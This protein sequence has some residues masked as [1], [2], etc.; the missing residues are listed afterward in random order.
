MQL[1]AAYQVLHGTLFG[2]SMRHVHHAQSAVN[3]CNRH[4]HAA[5]AMCAK[6]TL[7]AKGARIA[8]QGVVQRSSMLGCLGGHPS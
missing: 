4:V 6:A 5:T 7:P 2:V 1:V 3:A 8:S